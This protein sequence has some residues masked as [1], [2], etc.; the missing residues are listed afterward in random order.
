MGN[1][2][3]N[4]G[5]T[6]ERKV[7]KDFS[8]I[9]D[10]NFERVPNSGAFVGGKNSFRSQKITDEQML[11]MDGD[12]IVP[13]ELAHV[14]IECK[15]YKDFRWSKLFTTG[16]KNLDTWIK[17]CNMTSKLCWFICFKINN[18]GEYVVFDSHFFDAFTIDGN[19]LKYKSNDGIYIIVS[20]NDFFENNVEAILNL[21]DFE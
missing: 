10:L 21:R 16:E 4:K 2:S 6:Y 11:L 5:K 13:K 14:S 20:K 3:K 1:N 9:F 18:Y 19:Y 8:S 15:W 7:A 12:I 17:Q